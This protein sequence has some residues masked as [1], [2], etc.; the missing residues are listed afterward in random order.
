MS[1]LLEGLSSFTDPTFLLC[2]AVGT[3]LGLLVGFFPGVT[4]TMAAALAS[5]F[6]LSLEPEQGLAVMLTIYVAGQFGDRIPAILVNTP[7]TPSSIAT[8]LDGYPMAKNGQ[9]GLALVVSALVT[10]AALLASMLLFILVARPVADFALKFGPAEM[11]A[12]VLF[13]LTIMISIA[14]KSILKGL[15]AGLF[16]LI[17][18]VIG[19]DPITGDARFTFASNDLSSGLEFI[20]VIIGL[21][22]IAEVLDQ[23]LTHR[24]T[25]VRPISSLGRWWPTKKELKEIARPA[26]VGTGVGLGVGI[27]PAAGGDIA[28]L[29]GWDRA[30]AASKHPEK[31]GTGY[32]GGVA[33]SDSASSATLGGALTTTMALG[34]PGDS[35]MAVMIGSMIIWGIQPGPSMFTQHPDMVVLIA[36]I[37]IIATLVTGGLSLLRTKGMV[38]L[39]DMKPQHLW[40]IIL[41]FCMVGTYATTNNLFTVA[42]MLVFGFIGL[43]LKRAGIPAGPVV[44]GLLLGP[45]AESNLRRAL[46]IGGPESLVGSPISITLIALTVVVLL[47]TVLRR[48]KR[49]GK[50]SATPERDTVSV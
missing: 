20:A 8:T 27:V 7:G 13:G 35:V 28:G 15:I 41:I 4:M 21:F 45:L 47:G 16:G 46:V 17:I 26:A 12:L 32:I 29:V 5:G 25:T 1:T 11:F 10:T 3:V 42:T 33:A 23:M 40:V 48:K 34:I 38:R 43:A 22:G 44:L 49:S 9:A 50:P 18:A 30:R 36:A 19:R 6:T 2:M 39:L 24:A 14:S 31:F 37:M